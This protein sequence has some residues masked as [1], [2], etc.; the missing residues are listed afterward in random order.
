MIGRRGSSVIYSSGD[1]GADCTGS[2]TTLYPEYPSM[3][4]YVTAIGATEFISGNSGPEAAVSQFKSGGGFSSVFACPSYQCSAL[5]TYVKQPVPFPPSS[6]YVATN[7]ANP[8]FAALGSEFFQV[9]MDGFVYNVGGTSAS[10]PSFASIM[11]LLND[12][13]LQKGS[14]TLGF[15][16]PFLYN[17]AQTVPNAFFD[18]TQGNNYQGCGSSCSPYQPGYTCAVGYDAVTGYGTPNYAV[19]SQHV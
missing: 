1:N 5:A 9:V 16:N 13:R 4:V 15:L 8:D 2:C 10:A 19:L 14:S 6:K 3:S 11:V 18:V 7:R 12:L 17:L